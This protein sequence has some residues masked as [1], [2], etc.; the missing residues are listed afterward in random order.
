VSLSA[1]APRAWSQKVAST[2]PARFHQ[3][4]SW[5]ACHAIASGSTASPVARYARS[6]VRATRDAAK[7]PTS[8]ASGTSTSGALVQKSA[9]SARWCGQKERPS[10]ARRKSHATHTNSSDTSMSSSPVRAP[11]RYT[12]WKLVSSTRPAR[13]PA[14]AP[15]S[16]A[17]SDAVTS[18]V[19][20]PA[21]A[22]RI[23]IVQALLPATPI[24]VAR[25]K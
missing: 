2:A 20:A 19:A 22:E 14:R 8:T 6:R 11:W 12:N 23:R 13:N 4:A 5:S 17:P 15:A 9:Q 7:A 1:R 3:S 18:T 25:A 16:R 24:K 21:S 10:S